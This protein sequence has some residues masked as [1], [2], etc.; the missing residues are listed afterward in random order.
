MKNS[1]FHF[2]GGV[3]E[4][5]RFSAVFDFNIL[6]KKNFVGRKILRSR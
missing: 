2:S 3:I 1:P 6:Q 5:S 4:T